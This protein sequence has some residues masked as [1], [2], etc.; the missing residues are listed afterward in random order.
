V[1]RTALRHHKRAVLTVTV[2]VVDASGNVVTRT[3]RVRVER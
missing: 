3:V 2:N 1:L